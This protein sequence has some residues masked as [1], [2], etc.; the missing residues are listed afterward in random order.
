MRHFLRLLRRLADSID[1]VP[2]LTPWATIS[3][4]LRALATFFVVK[5]FPKPISQIADFVDN[6]C[7]LRAP[8][9]FYRNQELHCERVPLTALA[10]KFN[11]PLYVYSAATIR[12]RLRVF[13]RAFGNAWTD[14]QIKTT[15]CP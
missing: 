5:P 1:L 13:D 15:R 7:V 9:F 10:A 11:T 8:G 14:T 3:R 12:E 6:L 4:A 2:R